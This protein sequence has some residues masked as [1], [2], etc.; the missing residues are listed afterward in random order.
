MFTRFTRW[1]LGI[2]AA[3]TLLVGGGAALAA[4]GHRDYA[5]QADDSGFVQQ[6]IAAKSAASAS[7][8]S[9]CGAA[10]DAANPALT[11]AQLARLQTLSRECAAA[12]AAGSS[13]A[14][15]CPEAN[16]LAGG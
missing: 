13:D 4:H 6:C 2:T 12:K 11:P 15:A 8:G 1:L 10:N 3:S 14:S 7:A 5:R 16:A 9:L